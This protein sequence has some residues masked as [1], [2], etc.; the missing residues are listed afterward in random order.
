MESSVFIYATFRVTSAPF[1]SYMIIMGFD[2]TSNVYIPCV[3][4]LMCAK[5]EYLHYEVL[6]SIIVSLKYR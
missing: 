1:L 5:D 4:A 2:P 3:W 6:H